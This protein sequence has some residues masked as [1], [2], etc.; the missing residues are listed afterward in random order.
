MNDK[1]SDRCRWRC[2]A[3]AA[4][5]LSGLMGCT[6]LAPP[7]ERPALPVE[8]DYGPSA[9]LAA[10]PGQVSPGDLADWRAYFTDPALQALIVAALE[11]NR[12]L[13]L[14]ALRVDEA[15]HALG[16][17]ASYRWPGVSIDADMARA[18]TPAD[19]N[20]T[21]RPLLGNQYEIGLAQSAWEVD[22]WGRIRSLNDAARESY[23]AADA[24][25]HAAALALVVQV[26]QLYLA[27]CE[28]DERLGLARETLASRAA[29]HRIFSRR[30]AVGATSRLDLM[31]VETL[32]TQAQLMVAQ[33]EQAAAAN[34]HA[35]TLVVGARVEANTVF[36]PVETLTLPALAPGVASDLLTHRP[37]I[38]AA[39]HRLLAAN[40]NIGAARAAFFPRV[41]LTSNFNTASAAL[42]GLFDA[43]SEKWQFVPFISVPV[44]D[45]GRNVA[46]LSLAEVRKHMAV[47]DYER[48]IQAA[49]REVRD[50]LSATAWLSRQIDIQQQAVRAQAE[51]ARLAQLRYEHGATTYLEVLDA[52]RDLLTLQQSVVQINR[53]QRA[54]QVA[55]YGALG[56]V[57]AGAATSCETCP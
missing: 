11:H 17:Q 36:A 31:Q 46:N 41:A 3:M 9:A 7:Y 30:V 48:T 39:E 38:V 51:R 22:L 40:A 6:S 18:R 49:F 29:T 24:T 4:M 57:F 52:Q 12:D 43:G 32:L 34:R 21:Q 14:A 10:V 28:L 25:R 15:R 54:A 13:Q 42:S 47:A 23:L 37:D 33:L 45:G 56:G 19:L 53:Q 44:F 27:Q 20:L 55:L 35:L 16:V 8:A 5:T 50:A 26:A 2:A 1:R